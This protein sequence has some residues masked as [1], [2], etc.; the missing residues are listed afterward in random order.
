MPKQHCTC[1]KGDDVGAIAH[2][3]DCVCSD[4][5]FGEL[6]G[7]YDENN[8]MHNKSIVPE[9]KDLPPT[10]SI[11][12]PRM[13]RGGDRFSSDKYSTRDLG[14]H[15]HTDERGYLHRCYH[16]VRVRWYVWLLFFVFWAVGTEPVEQHLWAK[17]TPFKQIAEFVHLPVEVHDE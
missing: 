8:P 7:G 12:L 1:G 5:I 16:K 6:E 17:V 14:G 9:R 3:D 2:S 10:P 4:W 11:P 13:T 15:F